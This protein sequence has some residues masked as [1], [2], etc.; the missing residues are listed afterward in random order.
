MT[1]KTS[2]C[3]YVT[4]QLLSGTVLNRSVQGPLAWTDSSIA[5]NIGIIYM[6]ILK[7]Q[8]VLWWAQ[9]SYSGK[10]LFSVWQK[11]SSSTYKLFLDPFVKL[12]SQ[13]QEWTSFFS[14]WENLLEQGKSQIVQIQQ[15]QCNKFIKIQTCF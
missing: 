5:D 14:V 8:T 4:S 6:I 2:P 1:T 7:L 10:K 11:E 12:P 13:S 3:F 15:L 9:F